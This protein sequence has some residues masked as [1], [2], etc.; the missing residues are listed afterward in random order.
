MIPRSVSD[1]DL[2]ESVLIC[3]MYPDPY[4]FGFTGS[5][6]VLEILIRIQESENGRPKMNETARLRFLKIFDSNYFGLHALV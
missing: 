2:C 5:G 1:P 4:L 3:S 6:S